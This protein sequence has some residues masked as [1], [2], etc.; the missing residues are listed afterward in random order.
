MIRHSQG[1]PKLTVAQMKQHAF[2]ASCNIHPWA[3]RAD[4]REIVEAKASDPSLFTSNGALR[5]AVCDELEERYEE[6]TEQRR[7]RRIEEQRSIEQAARERAAARSQ[8]TV[9]SQRSSAPAQS[10]GQPPVIAV[11]GTASRLRE[12]DDVETELRNIAHKL[13]LLHERGAPD[14][15]EGAVPMDL[16]LRRVWKDQY[17]AYDKHRDKVAKLKQR[18]GKLERKLL[19]IGIS[20][21]RLRQMVSARLPP[22]GRRPV[23]AFRRT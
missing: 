19:T 3:H 22:R 10:D 6:L 17:R 21:A 8:Q 5:C 11:P 7:R 23:A 20:K 18:K 15:P 2:D 1:L 12:R 14:R 16:A 9:V 13:R 4:V